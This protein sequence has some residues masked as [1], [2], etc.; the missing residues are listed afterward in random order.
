MVGCSLGEKIS[1]SATNV[2]QPSAKILQFC[3]DDLVILSLHH[4][5]DS[6]L[7]RTKAAADRAGHEIGA[8]YPIFA[9]FPKIAS[10]VNRLKESIDLID[11][12]GREA[13][14]GAVAHDGKQPFACPYVVEA[15]N[16]CAQ[17][18]LRNAN[19]NLAR[20]RLLDGMCFIQNQKIIG[21]DVTAFVIC[22]FFSAAEQDKQ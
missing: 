14:A 2:G 4:L 22:E 18:I 12:L 21:K 11:K 6:R 19:S 16:R 13:D 10:L 7:Q 17:S 9:S 8:V 1:N 20:C 3:F 5:R 15:L